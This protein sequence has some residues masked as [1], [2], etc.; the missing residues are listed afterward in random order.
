MAAKFSLTESDLCCSVCYDVFRDPVL[1]RCS[2]SFCRTCVQDYW[3]GKRSA[4]RDCPLCRQEF[5]P[6]EDPVLNLSLKNL[7]ESYLQE[8]ENPSASGQGRGSGPLCHEHSE[9]LKLFCAEDKVPICVVCHSSRK[10]KGHEC[11]PVGEAALQWKELR[12]LLDVLQEKRVAFDKVKENCE[13]ATLH[14]KNQVRSSE[15]LIKEEFRKLRAFLEAEEESRVAALKAEGEEKSQRV[16]ESLEELTRTISSLSDSIAAIEEQLRAEDISL[17][18]VSA[19]HLGQ[20]LVVVA[21]HL[22]SL[23]FRVW[24]KMLGI[25]QNTPIVLDPNTAA[26]WLIL[27]DDLVSVIEGEEKQMFPNNPERFDLDAGVLGAEAFRSGTHC[28]EVE[29]GDSSTWVVGVAKESV[30]RKEK[31]ASVLKNGYLTLFFYQKMYFAGTSPLTRLTP[32]K[33]PQRLRVH[34]DCNRGRVSFFDSGDNTHLYTFK[35]TFS[36]SVFP[37]LWVGC[38][39]CPLRILPVATTIVPVQPNNA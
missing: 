23:N 16:N 14:I 1:L 7:C 6:Q 32:R 2:H 19:D 3:A 28:W 36:E 27:S 17:L 13:K 37:Y 12:A 9:P 21:S 31:L 20:V 35:H 22:G 11:S 34:L 18:H 5:S 15:R 10:H 30:Q 24:K 33:K 29:V 39:Q 25:V 8:D 4:R 38:K 26:P